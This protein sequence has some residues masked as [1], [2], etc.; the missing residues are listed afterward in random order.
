MKL[1]LVVFIWGFVCVPAVL[2]SGLCSPYFYSI[3]DS[4]VGCDALQKTSTWR[5]YWPDQ[6]DETVC[7][8][9]DGVCTVTLTCCDPSPHGLECWPEFLTPMAATEVGLRLFI[10]EERKMYLI[11]AFLDVTASPKQSAREAPKLP[12]MCLTHVRDRLLATHTPCTSSIR[13]S[14]G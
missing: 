1:K 12:T 13:E 11:H 8:S 6:T 10:T 4:F 2:A 9:G 5:I 14:C 3:G 7:A